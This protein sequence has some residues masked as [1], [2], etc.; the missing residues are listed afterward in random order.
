M[1]GLWMKK[2]VKVTSRA[3][4]RIPIA[5]QKAC[6]ISEGMI[7]VLETQSEDL[8]TLRCMRDYH[9]TPPTPP[10]LQIQADEHIKEDK[11]DTEM[12]DSLLSDE[13]LTHIETEASSLSSIQQSSIQIPT[14]EVETNNENEKVNGP[15]SLHTSDSQPSIEKNSI[16]DIRNH[17]D[18]PVTPKTATSHGSIVQTQQSPIHSLSRRVKGSGQKILIKPH[19]SAA[20]QPLHSD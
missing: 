2:L 7:L 4:I 15:S 14:Q 1:E 17:V 11:S 13:E 20:D 6:N 3:Q 5:V 18:S 9:E 19:S 8:I 10:L 12:P 16:P